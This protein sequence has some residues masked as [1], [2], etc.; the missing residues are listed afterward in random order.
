M[1]SADRKRTSEHFVILSL[2]NS[3]PFAEEEEEEEEKLALFMK[4]IINFRQMI[5]C[6]RVLLRKDWRIINLLL[7]SGFM[8]QLMRNV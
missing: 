5:R 4:R 2:L 6:K 1:A 3:C 7:D 8:C